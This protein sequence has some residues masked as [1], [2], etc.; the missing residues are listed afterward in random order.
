M[1]NNLK[2]WVQTVIPLV[3]D[4]SLSLYELVNKVVD[5]LN[6]VINNQNLLNDQ[7]K[8]FKNWVDQLLK[9]YTIDQLNEW[10]TDGTFK[11]LINNLL[12]EFN[13]ELSNVKFYGAKGD[14]ITDDTASI[15][16]ALDLTGKLYFPD[17]HYIINNTLLV[18]NKDLILKGENNSTLVFN[19]IDKTGLRIKNSESIQ[20]YN[21]GFESPVQKT[22]QDDSKNQLVLINLSSNIIIDGVKTSD[23]CTGIWIADSKNIVVRNCVFTGANWDGLAL[24]SLNT[25]C[26]LLTPTNAGCF[27]ALIYNNEAYNNYNGFKF[28]YFMHDIIFENNYS[29]DNTGD[30]LDFAGYIVDGFTIKNNIFK[31]C[32]LN[33][34]SI[35]NLELNDYPSVIE[36]YNFKFQNIQ[37]LNNYFYNIGALTLDFQNYYTDIPTKNIVIE[38]NVLEYDRYVVSSSPNNN[39]IRILRADNLNI[40]DYITVCNNMIIGN[41]C[42][43]YG[44]RVTNTQNLK[45]FNNHV[46]NTFK[47]CIFLDQQLIN[48]IDVTT[49]NIIIYDNYLYSPNN[50]FVN[51]KQCVNVNADVNPD[52]FLNIQVIKNKVENNNSLFVLFSLLTERPENYTCYDN[53]WITPFTDYPQNM[54][55]YK[56]L[57]YKSKL[58]LQT[59]CIGWIGKTSKAVTTNNETAIYI[60][61]TT[62]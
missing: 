14:G 52:K 3:Y 2:W 17:G 34:C 36:K 26:N 20:F 29:H 31:E 62:A 23:S 35:K 60:P 28:A 45:I 41:D 16:K 1:I 59:N 15:Q 5:K 56:G 50:G 9:D 46:E 49:H 12:L 13:Q 43:T 37:Y 25:N 10:L 7:F 4:N 42:L 54:R 19:F 47:D 18:E 8:E 57:I 55:I 22:S 33:G 53:E 39:G 24:T 51:G 32:V 40:S 38:N 61:I 58:P 27:N 30:G 48:Q 21:I 6:E 11:N 44:I